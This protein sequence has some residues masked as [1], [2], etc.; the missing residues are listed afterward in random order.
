L[1]GP[2]AGGRAGAN[3]AVRDVIAS[4]APAVVATG[5]PA[6]FNRRGA[7]AFYNAGDGSII[8]MIQGASAGA[9]LGTS[10]AVAN[11]DGAFFPA[12]FAVSAPGAAGGGEVLL[13]GE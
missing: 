11:F 6:A 8:Q 12:E 3:L 4:G 2:V 7:V 10:L 1:D 9:E 5:M 13:L